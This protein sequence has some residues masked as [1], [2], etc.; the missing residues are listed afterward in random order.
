M[1]IDQTLYQPQLGAGLLEL[2]AA[3]ERHR[4]QY[5]LIGGLAVSLHSRPRSTRDIDIL[6][7]VPQVTL[8]GLLG[9]L[10]EH[11]FT[12]DEPAVITAYVRHHI[13]AFEYHGVRVDWLKPVVPMYQHVL[14]TAGTNSGFG[15]PV[16]VATAEGLLLLKLMAG[17]P[18]DLVDIDSLLAA[19]KGELNLDWVEREWI[20]LYPADDPR[21]QKFQQSV[22]EY[23]ERYV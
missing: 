18:Q 4:V 14:D 1:A 11:G 22:A 23:Y 5:A 12:L 20:T 8:P 10:T 6:L 16:R 21:W 3:L 7:A 2:V 17:R 15:R 9:D 19:N 13:T